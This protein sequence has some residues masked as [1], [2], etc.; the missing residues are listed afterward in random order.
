MRSLSVSSDPW[1]L[2]LRLLYLAYTNASRAITV[3]VAYR[4]TTMFSTQAAAQRSGQTGRTN[5]SHQIFHSYPTSGSAQLVMTS[6]L[7]VSTSKVT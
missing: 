2:E 4:L 5:M 3:P 1:S 7:Q 6:S